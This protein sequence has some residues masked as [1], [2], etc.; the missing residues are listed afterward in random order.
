MTSLQQLEKLT[1]Q[2]E[3]LKRALYRADASRSPCAVVYVSG[4]MYDLDGTLNGFKIT[5]Y[6]EGKLNWKS[7]YTLE[8]LTPLDIKA[9]T[10]SHPDLDYYLEWKGCLEWVVEHKE[11]P[12]EKEHCEKLLL[13]YYN[14]GQ[15]SFDIDYRSDLLKEA[16]RQFPPYMHYIG[17]RN[18]TEVTK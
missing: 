11:D 13:N 5:V 3:Q 15:K 14:K 7:C 16:L 17:N 9:F 6:P 12:K 18:R 4:S 2:A 8:D 1:R 10:D